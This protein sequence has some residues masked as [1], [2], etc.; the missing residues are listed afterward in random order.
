MRDVTGGNQFSKGLLP[1]LPPQNIFIV[2]KLKLINKIYQLYLCLKK[3][4]HLHHE[5]L[6]V[7]A[8]GSKVVANGPAVKDGL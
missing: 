3:G 4:E 1:P 8:K 5:V 6:E 2:L 7:V